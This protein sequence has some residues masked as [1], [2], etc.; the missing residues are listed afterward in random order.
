MNDDLKTIVEIAD[1]LDEPT[2]RV[3]YIVRK[4]RVRAVRRVGG[5]RLFGPEGVELIK[6]GLYDIQLRG[7]A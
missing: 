4:H 3:E 6:H 2:Q 1:A 7:G 5:I